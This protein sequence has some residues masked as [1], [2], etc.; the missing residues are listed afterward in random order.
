MS[1]TQLT[2]AEKKRF[3]AMELQRDFLKHK[4]KPELKEPESV[5]GVKCKACH[6][7]DVVPRIITKT[8]GHA[9]DSHYRRQFKIIAHYYCPWCGLMYDR[10]FVESQTVSAN[11]K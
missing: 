5:K 11:G 4:E 9:M 6:C 1:E 8:R 3:A 2:D 7:I 10:E